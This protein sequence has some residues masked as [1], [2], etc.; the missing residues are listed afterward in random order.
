MWRVEAIRYVIVNST[1][2]FSAS[3]VTRTTL[4]AWLVNVKY[5]GK[6]DENV[7]LFVKNRMSEHMLRNENHLE[8]YKLIW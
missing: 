7:I 5:S 3:F 1:L 8:W 6:I 2:T 4:F